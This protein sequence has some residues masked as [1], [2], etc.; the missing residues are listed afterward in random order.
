[1]DHGPA[2]EWKEDAKTSKIKSKIG[3]WMFLGYTIV[4]A[5]FI[6]FNVVNPKLMGM[7]IGLVNL[8]IIFGFGL[9]VLALIMALIYNALCGW[10]E[11]K[12]LKL[13]KLEKKRG[14]KKHG[15]GGHK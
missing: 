13:E 15:E 12:A 1:M 8:A 11:E 10:A 14:G 2:T 4:Y 5:V 7:D 9:I 6:V 3:I